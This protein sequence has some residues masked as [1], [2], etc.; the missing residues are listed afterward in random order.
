MTSLITQKPITAAAQYRGDWMCAAGL[1][2]TNP[3]GSNPG[4]SDEGREH[5]DDTSRGSP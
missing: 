3:F 5:Q 4:P 1:E 2:R